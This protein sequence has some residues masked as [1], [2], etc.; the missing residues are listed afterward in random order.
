M[1]GPTL[2]SMYPIPQRYYVPQRI[3]EDYYSRL[4]ASGLPNSPFEVEEKP[5]E[6]W[7]GAIPRLRGINTDDKI[8]KAFERERVYF[9]LV[10]VY[11]MLINVGRHWR[12]QKQSLISTNLYSLTKDIYSENSE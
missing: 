9:I 1:T 6:P 4:N 10:L 7:K 2:A 12:K 8:R 5:N 3:R 11:V